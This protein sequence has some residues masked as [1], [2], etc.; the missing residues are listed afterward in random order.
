MFRA[1]G[2]E[3]RDYAREETRHLQECVLL[4]TL[5]MHDRGVQPL[6]YTLAKGSFEKSFTWRSEKINHMG[7]KYEAASIFKC[8]MERGVAM[9]G[10]EKELERWK[11]HG[12]LARLSER[13]AWTKVSL[14]GKASQEGGDRARR[15]F[16]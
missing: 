11:P 15:E 13:I 16:A 2:S 6:A 4:P 9:R 10:K 8:P 12:S 3:K 7:E 14:P 5:V 1:R